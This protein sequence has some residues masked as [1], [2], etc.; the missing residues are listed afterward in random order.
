MTYSNYSQVE[1]AIRDR[2]P[3]RGNSATGELFYGVYMVSSYGTLIASF[4]ED[5]GAWV[6][7]AYYSK[8]TSRLQNVVKRVW[9]VN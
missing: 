2:V 9:G 7:S 5:E 8:T 3:F 6:S 1:S 4:S